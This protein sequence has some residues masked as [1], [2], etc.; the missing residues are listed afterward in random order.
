VVEIE[1]IQLYVL[2]GN[3]CLKLFG[4][5]F[6]NLM[7]KPV[8]TQF[9]LQKSIQKQNQQNNAKQNTKRYFPKLSQG[10]GFCKNSQTSSLHKFITCRRDEKF[11]K[12]KNTFGLTE[13]FVEDV[14]VFACV[15][16]FFKMSG[17]ATIWLMLRGSL[18]LNNL[19]SFPAFKL[20]QALMIMSAAE[21]NFLTYK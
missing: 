13:A 19:S 15:S 11:V 9:C 3:F 2:D 16:T 10:S 5:T 14:K 20:L 6:C 12:D 17:I 1:K 21:R 7:S 18:H 4:E 8:L